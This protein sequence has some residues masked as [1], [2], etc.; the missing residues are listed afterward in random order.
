MPYRWLILLLLL[1]P[2]AGC[3]HQKEHALCRVWFDENTLNRR[4][5]FFQKVDH[6]PYEG[7]RVGYY[8]WMYGKDP[9]H[10]GVSPL[11][12]VTEPAPPMMMPDSGIPYG[13]GPTLVDPLPGQPL[14][15]QP[16]P[17]PSGSQDAEPSPPLPAPPTEPAESEYPTVGTPRGNIRP[18]GA[19]L[20]HRP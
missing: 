16:L 1:A 3:F 19:W 17:A 20:F 5:L 6:L 13:Y 10:Q 18:V 7:K 14:P 9:G 2:T 4:A 11:D 15:G 8:R 12:G